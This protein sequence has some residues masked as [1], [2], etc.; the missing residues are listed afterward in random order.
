MAA[1]EAVEAMQKECKELK[2]HYDEA[3][4]TIVGMQLVH[5]PGEATFR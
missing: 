5:K 3:T 4:K 2:H 1:A